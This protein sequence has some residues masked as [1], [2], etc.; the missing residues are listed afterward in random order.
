VQL[1]VA[2]DLPGTDKPT[3]HVA[4]DAAG[5]LYFQNRNISD[6]QL[7]QQLSNSIAKMPVK[8]TLVLRVDRGAAHS[9]DVRLLLIARDVG[10]DNVIFATQ[11][12]P[13]GSNAVKP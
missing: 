8:P 1:P 4:M 9:N 3:L 13:F 5:R 6:A 11:P 2:V 12:G 10:V 7:R